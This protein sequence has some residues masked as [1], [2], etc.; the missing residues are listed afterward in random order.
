MMFALWQMMLA[1]PIMTA[2][3]MMCAL[4]H[5]DTNITSLRHAARQHHICKANASYRRRRCIIYQY[6]Q[7]FNDVCLMAN[8][9]GCTL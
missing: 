5:V 1:S 6:L 9:V 2:T 8:D 4:R 7:I 3:L